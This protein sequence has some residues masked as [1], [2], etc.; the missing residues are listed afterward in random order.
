MCDHLEFNIPSE[1]PS[2]LDLLRKSSSKNE[3]E[4]VRLEKKNNQMM[5]TGNIVK[6]DTKK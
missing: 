3:A 1:F 5:Q 6:A 4:E 2:S